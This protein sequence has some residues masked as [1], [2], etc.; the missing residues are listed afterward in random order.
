MQRDNLPHYPNQRD[1]DNAAMVGG[2]VFIFGIFLLGGVAGFLVRWFRLMMISIFLAFVI[3][4]TITYVVGG[5]L[6][7]FPEWTLPPTLPP[8]IAV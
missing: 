3:P 4:F 8:G 7:E 6:N 2:C 5:G 1:Q